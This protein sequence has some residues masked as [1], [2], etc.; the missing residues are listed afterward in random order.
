MKPIIRNVISGCRKPPKH[1]ILPALLLACT[2]LVT[3]ASQLAGAMQIHNGGPGVAP[4]SPKQ[5]LPSQ[6]TP[7][8]I[9]SQDSRAPQTLKVRW[10][11]GKLSVDAEGAPLMEV[12]RAVSRQTGIV[13]SG[14]QGHRDPVFAHL[15][16]IDWREA[17]QSLLCRL[18]YAIITGPSPAPRGARV[19]IFRGG[20]G[21]G[22]GDFHTGASGPL[23][24]DPEDVKLKAVEDAVQGKDRRTLKSLI[25]DND[26]TVQS[27]AF[28]ALAAQDKDLAVSLLVTSARRNPDAAARL[29][30]LQLLEQTDTADEQLRISTLR[31]SLRDGDPSVSAYAIQSLASNGNPAA[32]E[33]L[34]V[35]FH[36][37]D[38][39]TRWM[40][41]QSVAGTAAAAPLLHEALSDPDEAVSGLAATLLKQSEA[42]ASAASQ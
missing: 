21:T 16:G 30:S 38:P 32:V 24:N 12:L 23:S 3:S 42:S 9:T 36:S 18:N 14:A 37:G 40:L 11:A 33:A 31:E 13:V 8:P 34:S 27:A 41:I 15:E 28:E 6:N 39:S 17:L 5:P 19:V 7:P 29:Q 20:P 35:A 25:Q 22:Q 2:L 1:V 4:P 26:P 10:A